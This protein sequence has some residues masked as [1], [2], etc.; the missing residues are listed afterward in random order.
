MADGNTLLEWVCLEVRGRRRRRPDNKPND[1]HT[2]RGRTDL[3][4]R[5]SIAQTAGG[6]KDEKR[7]VESAASVL[8]YR[9]ANIF[10]GLRG[11][12]KTLRPRRG[13]VRSGGRCSIPAD[14]EQ[15]RAVLDEALGVGG[16]PLGP[17]TCLRTSDSPH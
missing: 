3:K 2:A 6:V 11:V 7:P 15:G 8:S 5:K 10:R 4:S 16:A 1:V 17:R 14:P 12:P 9:F 13:R